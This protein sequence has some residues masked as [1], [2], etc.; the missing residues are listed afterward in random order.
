MEAQGQ[1]AKR[2]DRYWLRPL[3][4]LP[5]PAG[6]ETA[7]ESASFPSQNCQLPYLFRNQMQVEAKGPLGTRLP[8]ICFID[9]DSRNRHKAVLNTPRSLSKVSKL[10]PRFLQ[11]QHSSHL[12][13]ATLT[14]NSR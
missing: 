1:V 8:P 7:Q 12:L 4:A 9:R 10:E 2:I 14:I 6:G 5:K 3:L 13:D 11:L